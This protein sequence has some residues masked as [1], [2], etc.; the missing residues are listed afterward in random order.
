[1]YKLKEATQVENKV[2]MITYLNAFDGKMAS[3]LRDKDPRTLRDALE[4]LG[5]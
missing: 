2:C 4:L 5:I 1:M 3:Q